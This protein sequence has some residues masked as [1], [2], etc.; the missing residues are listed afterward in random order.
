MRNKFDEQL[1][2][3]NLELIKMGA[4]C[5]DAIKAS[6]K[7]LLEGDKNMILKT[8]EIEKEIDDKERYIESRCFL[9]LLKQQTGPH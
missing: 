3:L 2:I 1:E 7:A 5:E 4:L 9:N 6:M 8:I